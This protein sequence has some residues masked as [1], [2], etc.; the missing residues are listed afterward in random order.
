[1]PGDLNSSERRALWKTVLVGRHPKRTLFRA[2][3]L[4]IVSVVVFKFIL[5]PVRISG[6]SMD[7]TY[8]DGRINFINRLPYVKGDPK[9][10]DVVGIRMAGT[11]VQLF[12]RVVGLPGETVAIRHGIL[13]INGE[14]L[15][16]PYLQPESINRLWQLPETQ[17][18]PGQYFVIGDNRSMEQQFHE[19][20]IAERLRIVGKVLL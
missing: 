14:P 5:L 17:L 20:G 13:F 1:M 11:R 7:P 12:K 4:L 16:E 19:F 6:I 18:G 8:R 9:R 10:Y 15:P 3:S 2:T